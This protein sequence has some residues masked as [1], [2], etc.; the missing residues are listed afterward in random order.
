MIDSSV[1]SLQSSLEGNYLNVPLYH[2]AK[3][4]E[5]AVNVLQEDCPDFLIPFRLMS[6]ND[7]NLLRYKLIN[8]IA[9]EYSNLTLPGAA[10]AEMYLSLLKPFLKGKDWFLNYHNICIDKKYVYL[11]KELTQAF[12]IYIP[13]ESCC[14]SDEEILHFFQAVLNNVTI[15]DDSSFMVRLYQYFSRG[16]TTLSDLYLIV[17]DENKKIKSVVSA[18]EVKSQTYTAP[19][20]VPEINAA[21]RER[22]QPVEAPVQRQEIPAP[23]SVEKEKKTGLFGGGKKKGKKAESSAVSPEVSFG[24]D[25]FG[26]DDEVM[27]ALF[28]EEKKK[29]KEKPLKQKKE[30]VFSEEKG[31]GLFGGRKKSTVVPEADHESAVS[32]KQDAVNSQSGYMQQDYIQ[33]SIPEPL[34]SGEDDTTEICEDGMEQVGGYLELMDGS[35]QGAPVRIELSFDKPYI[36]LGRNSSN[37]VKPDVLFDSELKRIGRM[38]ARIE[39]RE[40]APY[41]IDLGSANHTSLNG[42]VLIPN[43]PYPLKN[44]DELTFAPGT[45]IRYRVNL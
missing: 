28:G 11:N 13:E 31:K 32:E 27:K 44:G 6:R 2:A 9:L 18:G 23:V 5:I 29:K 25:G 42:Q 35:I 43:C 36:T 10:F 41:I 12:Y 33:N 38:H 1:F 14:N 15:T 17:E 16:D 39:K 30:K 4:D 21:E 20:T 19:Q 8:A 37:S 3:L 45:P 26:S 34:M 7:N 22:V 24:A 40:D